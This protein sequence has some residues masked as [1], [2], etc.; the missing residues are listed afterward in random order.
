MPLAVPMVPMAAANGANGANGRCQWCQWPCQWRHLT[1]PP[2]PDGSAPS[3]ATAFL[4]DDSES[5]NILYTTLGDR[6]QGRQRMVK[7]R[8]VKTTLDAANPLC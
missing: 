6:I 5:S 1:I 8:G 7:L 3:L 4:T 2:S